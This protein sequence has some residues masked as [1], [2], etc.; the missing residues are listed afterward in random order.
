MSSVFLDPFMN[1]LTAALDGLGE[2]GDREVWKCWLTAYDRIRRR[3]VGAVVRQIMARHN[4][5]PEQLALELGAAGA[6]FAYAAMEGK[7]SLDKFQLMMDIFAPGECLLPPR[8]ERFAAA[9]M[10]TMDFVRQRLHDPIERPVDREI[11]EYVSRATRCKQWFVAREEGDAATIRNLSLQMCDEVGEFVEK[12]TIKDLT[13]LDRII[14]EWSV[15]YVVCVSI[16]SALEG[17]R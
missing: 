16:V 8:R 17:G 3:H 12:R 15:A 1:R 2:A 11:Y 9:T 6:P 10:T 13:D 5:K 14:D 4:L 7:I